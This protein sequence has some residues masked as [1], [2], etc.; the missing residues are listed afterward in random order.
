MSP[1]DLEWCRTPRLRNKF[2]FRDS[3]PIRLHSRID[4]IFG[5]TTNTNRNGPFIRQ[6]RRIVQLSNRAHTSAQI[7]NK[8]GLTGRLPNGSWITHASHTVLHKNLMYLHINTK[9]PELPRF[10]TK[11]ARSTHLGPTHGRLARDP[12]VPLEYSTHLGFRSP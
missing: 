11:Q 7:C 8:Q 9:N 2:H 4:A 12:V 5:K 1:M 6:T 3:G 10:M